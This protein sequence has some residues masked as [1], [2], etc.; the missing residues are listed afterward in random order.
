ME[1]DEFCRAL[2]REAS[3]TAA[4]QAL[5][6]VWWHDQREPGIAM[7]ATS[8]AAVLKRHA[9][10]NPNPTALKA[11]IAKLRM[12]V[13]VDGQFKIKAGARETL[14]AK[15]SAVLKGEPPLIEQE[16]GYLPSHVWKGTRGYIES[17]CEEL[18]GCFQFGFFNGASVLLRRL[19]ETLLIEV[20][21]HLR[22]DAE[23]RN[24]DGNYWML[25]DLV[26]HATGSNGLS[27][28]R[29][30]KKAL[31]AV[32]ELGD[33]AAHNRRFCAKKADMEKIE[34]AVR[35]LADELIALAGLRHP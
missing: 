25:G 4:D 23:V 8:L 30:A 26:A 21:E 5:C 7:S 31:V 6:I 10:G 27:I 20:Y 32:K 13:R 17:V 35:V 9:L 15:L 24:T 11:G 1:L 22:R 29:E 19:V 16:A 2:S 28:G 34:S 33:R 18:N 14:R 3:M 12:T